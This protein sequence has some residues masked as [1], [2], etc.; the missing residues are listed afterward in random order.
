MLL[1]EAYKTYVDEVQTLHKL[2]VRFVDDFINSHHFTDCRCALGKNAHFMNLQIVKGILTTRQDL[3]EKYFAAKSP[4]AVQL[5][6]M[7]EEYN[8]TMPP[9][10]RFPSLSGYT[11]DIP[12]TFGCYFGK[13]EISL[14]TQCA[15]EAF[16]FIGH[17]GEDE[18]EALFSCKLQTPLSV[19]NNRKAAIFFDELSRKDLICREWQMV[20][21]KNGLLTSSSGS[22]LTSNKLSSALSQSRKNDVKYRPKFIE[23][24]KQLQRIQTTAKNESK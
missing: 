20:I 15:F 1:S 21:D 10:H 23:M 16:L 5:C 12:P 13:T 4:S 2:Y 18:I 24:A 22:K 14:I 6:S 17:C 3:V 7:V 9:T 8:T 19:S 11:N